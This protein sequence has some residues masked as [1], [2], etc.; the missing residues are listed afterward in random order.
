M[1]KA[2]NQAKRRVVEN[3]LE[4]IGQA[5]HTEDAEYDS[6]C[7]RFEALRGQL[8][9]IER[10]LTRFMDSLTE[11]ANASSALSDDFCT[12]LRD[13]TSQQ[14]A[15]QWADGTK[16]WDTVIRRSAVL[17]LRERA[18]IPVQALLCERLRAISAL[19]EQR[20]GAVVDY[21]SYRRRTR[22]LKESKQQDAEKITAME[23]KLE[24]A[25]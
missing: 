4:R 11:Y 23:A 6:A 3:V 13:S 18:L 24:K 14:T 7:E 17:L 15:Q 16:N 9:A 19:I 5:E 25:T 21:D 20:K 22:E 10:R 2:I 8:S 1:L 12:F